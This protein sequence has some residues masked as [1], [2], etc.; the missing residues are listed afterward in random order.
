[1]QNAAIL[2]F[3]QNNEVATFLNGVSPFLSSTMEEV[4][5]KI[6]GDGGALPKKLCD[7][8]TAKFELLQEEQD[9]LRNSF[10]RICQIAYEA[11]MSKFHEESRKRHSDPILQTTGVLNKEELAQMAET[12]IHLES[13]RKQVVLDEETVGGPIDV[14]VITKGDGLVWIK[15]KHYFRPELNHHFFKNYFEP[16]PHS[17]FQGELHEHDDQ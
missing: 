12:L 5:Q 8:I 10:G 17:E 16:H 4:F 1:M 9:D 15:R 14:A 2:T 3:A 11:A 6:F 7:N 13:F